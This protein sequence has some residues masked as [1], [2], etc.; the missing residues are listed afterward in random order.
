MK[1]S[2]GL[3]IYNIILVHFVMLIFNS[4]YTFQLPKLLDSLITWIGYDVNLCL[5]WLVTEV[6][7][8]GFLMKLCY[9]MNHSLPPVPVSSIQNEIFCMN[10]GRW[11]WRRALAGR[12]MERRGNQGQRE[13]SLVRCLHESWPPSFLHGMIQIISP[14]RTSHLI[15]TS[16]IFSFILM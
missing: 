13:P 3:I 14:Q 4:K 5:L 12:N 16:V 10:G 1:T 8:Q 6:V 9:H 7:F 2:F 11:Q 15:A